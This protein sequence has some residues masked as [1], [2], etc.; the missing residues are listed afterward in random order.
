MK[1]LTSSKILVPYF[2]S[3][4]FIMITLNKL[5]ENIGLLQHLLKIFFIFLY[6]FTL[7]KYYENPTEMSEPFK[8]FGRIF[9]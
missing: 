9:S 3:F 6:S 5:Y 4:F 2:S 7:W 1:G 8:I